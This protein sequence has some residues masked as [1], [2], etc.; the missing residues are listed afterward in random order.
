MWN[1]LESR[2]GKVWRH[3]DTLKMLDRAEQMD[4]LLVQLTQAAG[5]KMVE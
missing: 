4:A 3:R 2:E 5:V 1:D